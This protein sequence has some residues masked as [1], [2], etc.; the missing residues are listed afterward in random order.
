MGNPFSAPTLQA[1]PAAP[2]DQPSPTDELVQ[3]AAEAQK[4]RAAMGT[5]LSSTFL[6]G[7][8]GISGPAP[9]AGAPSLKGG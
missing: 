2:T 6:T 1:A 7:P 8:M 5:S 3:Q 4:R 9:T